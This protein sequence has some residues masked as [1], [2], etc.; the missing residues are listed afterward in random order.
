[1]FGARS[2]AQLDEVLP[3]ASLQLSDAQVRRLD[4]ASAL[5]LGYPYDFMKRVQGRW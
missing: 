2:L 5:D 3:A 4:E 1:V